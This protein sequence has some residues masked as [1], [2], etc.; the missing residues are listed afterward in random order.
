MNG[1]QMQV[2]PQP[3]KHLNPLNFG[4]ECNEHVLIILII[5]INVKLL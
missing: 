3:N 4:Y 2:R 5:L 1:I